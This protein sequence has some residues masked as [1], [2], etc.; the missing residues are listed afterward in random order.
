[1]NRT[2]TYLSDGREL[3]FFDEQPGGDR[4]VDDTRGL[5][6][7]EPAPELRH[8]PLVDDW[9]VLAAHRQSRTHLPPTDECPLC[10]PASQRATEVPSPA[11]DVVESEN[12]FPSLASFAPRPERTVA[13]RELFARRADDGLCEVVCFT[14]DH[15]PS[16][17]QLSQPRVGTVMQAWADRTRHLSALP[18]G[19]VVA[20]FEDRGEEIGVTLNHP[21]GQVYA[22]PFVPERTARMLRAARRYRD[23]T[24][25]DLAALLR[26]KGE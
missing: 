4:R 22:Y 17:A 1:M 24:G 18:G 12:R 25:A 16:F 21:H 8:D 11:Y 19:Q 7:T 5:L 6:P 9:V 3:C 20:P 23:R 15:S 10:P 14:D 13:G 2:S 26:E